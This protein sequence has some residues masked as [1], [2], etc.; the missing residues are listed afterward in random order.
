MTT[1]RETRAIFLTWGRPRTRVVAFRPNVLFRDFRLSR[2]FKSSSGDQVERSVVHGSL[3]SSRCTPPPPPKHL[4]RCGLTIS[5]F[6]VT[7]IGVASETQKQC[8]PVLRS[9]VQREKRYVG[10]G[11]HSIRD[12]VPAKGLRRRKSS[13]LGQQNHDGAFVS[14]LSSGSLII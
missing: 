5:C 2:C 9:A 12:D 14:F 8:V 6:N 3:V 1:K 4:P 7:Y 10:I 13:S 11:L